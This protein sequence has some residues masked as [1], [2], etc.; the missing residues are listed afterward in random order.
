L[1]TDKDGKVVNITIEHAKDQAEITNFSF[2][3][4]EKKAV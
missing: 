3:Q 1:E 4:V 2:N